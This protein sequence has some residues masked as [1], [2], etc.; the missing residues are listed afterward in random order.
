MGQ[1]ITKPKT[2][3]KKAKT[4][5][6]LLDKAAQ[7]FSR[8]GYQATS[9][10]AIAS[11][12]NMKAGSLYYHFASKEVMMVE[13]L[14]RSIQFISDTVYEEVEKLGENYSFEDALKAYITGHLTAILKHSDYTATIIRNDGQI[15]AGVQA[16]V[17]IKREHYEQQWRNLMRHGKEQGV[18][19]QDID[20]RVL[21]LMI[22]GCLNWSAVWYKEKGESIESL[23]DLYTSVFLNGCR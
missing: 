5:E 10:K 11:A 17:D 3:H 7:F 19:R 23:A 4:R 20:A 6:L 21:R 16:S 1:A 12:A 14:D 8:H 15:P 2:G 18:I 9:L 13:V 22:L